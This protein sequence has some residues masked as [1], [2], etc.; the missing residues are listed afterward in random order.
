MLPL[1][2]PL[3]FPLPLPLPLLLPSML[4]LPLPLPLLL[5]LSLPASQKSHFCFRLCYHPKLTSLN[6]DPT[7]YDHLST[8]SESQI[9]DFILLQPN[10]RPSS[11]NSPLLTLPCPQYR[12]TPSSSTSSPKR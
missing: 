3:M 1:M 10:Q 11:S 4:P 5:P 9:S 6:P 12:R 8:Y 7:S 2:L